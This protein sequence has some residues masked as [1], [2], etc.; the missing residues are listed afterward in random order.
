LDNE[1]FLFKSPTQRSNE[2][3]LKDLNNHS[4][5]L[6][7]LLETILAKKYKNLP[8]NSVAFS[9]KRALKRGGMF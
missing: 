9:N 4:F 8:P 5:N 6:R 7:E 3:Y 1:D 2:E